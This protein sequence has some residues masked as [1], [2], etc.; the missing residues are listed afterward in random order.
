MR[1]KEFCLRGLSFKN[2]CYGPSELVRGTSF[3]RGKKGIDTKNPLAL[4]IVVQRKTVVLWSS[5]CTEDALLNSPRFWPMLISILATHP[6]TG[7]I[8][9][10]SHFYME[11]CMSSDLSPHRTHSI[12]H[13][14]IH[15][16]VHVPTTTRLPEI[17]KHLNSQS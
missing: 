15:S 4:E 10:W 17:I 3:M 6:L 14:T 16:S 13:S 9:N 12:F 11:N 5:A 8:L 2:C 1:N 7:Y